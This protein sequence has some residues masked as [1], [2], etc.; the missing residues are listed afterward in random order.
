[1]DRLERRRLALEVQ[2]VAR[3]RGHALSDAAAATLDVLI[4]DLAA[5]PLESARA[6]V[7]AR[8]RALAGAPGPHGGHQC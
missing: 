6:L 5:L 7:L 8:L 4:A 1:M 3:A 2:D